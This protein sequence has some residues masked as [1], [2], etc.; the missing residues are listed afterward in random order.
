MQK[1]GNYC[2]CVVVVAAVA[3]AVAPNLNDSNGSRKIFPRE[4][5]K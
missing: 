3:A 2:C 5:T 1:V 4:S